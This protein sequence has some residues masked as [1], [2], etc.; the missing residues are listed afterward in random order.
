MGWDRICLQCSSDTAA[1]QGGKVEAKL[2]EVRDAGTF[3]PVLAVKVAALDE[4]ERYLLEA[5]GYSLDPKRGEPY[6]LLAPI[7]PGAGQFGRI[8]YD[9]YEWR[10]SPTLRNAHLYI[11]DNWDSLAARAVVDVEYINGRRAEPKVSQRVARR[12]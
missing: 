7:D 1:C 11:V 3:M 2:F 12:S 8:N 4:A 6:V 9:G 5:A 10:K